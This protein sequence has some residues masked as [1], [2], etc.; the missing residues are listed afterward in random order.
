[1]RTDNT[2]NYGIDWHDQARLYVD[3]GVN[4]YVMI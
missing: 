3:M 2:I 1:M 4:L